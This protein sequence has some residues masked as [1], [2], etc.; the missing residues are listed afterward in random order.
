MKTLI[1]VL[2]IFSSFANA[3]Q[4]VC[5]TDRVFVKAAGK[6]EALISFRFS[7][8][9]LRDGS[10]EL[11]NFKGTVKY[12]EYLITTFAEAG[13]DIYNIQ[14]ASK[15]LKSN[16]NYRPIKFKGSWQFKD[17]PAVGRSSISPVW[18]NLVI[19]P[20]KPGENYFANLLITEDQ[21]GAKALLTCKTIH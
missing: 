14:Y 13:D 12:P 7:E 21:N 6:T 4:T 15:V 16:P 17:L 2:M 1:L 5:K 9:Q 8:A 10:L 18:V 20:H 3:S 19:P 11:L